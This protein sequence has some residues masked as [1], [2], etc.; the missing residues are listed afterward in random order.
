MYYYLH[1]YEGIAEMV[2][3]WS[4][5]KAAKNKDKCVKCA[6]FSFSLKEVKEPF[7]CLDK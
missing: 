5:F 2:C 1:N 4:F 3:L 6:F 7:A